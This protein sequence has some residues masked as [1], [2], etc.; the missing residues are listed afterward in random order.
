MIEDFQRGHDRIDLRSI[1]A[2]TGKAGDQAFKLVNAFNNH[3]GQALYDANTH[4]L[5]GDVNGD[6]HADFAIEIIGV[7]KLAAADILL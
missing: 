7:A 6:G 5:Q 2:N 3:A 4:M 1:D